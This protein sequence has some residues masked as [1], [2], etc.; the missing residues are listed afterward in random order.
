[1]VEFGSVMELHRAV[2]HCG[3]R[4]RYSLDQIGCAWQWYSM[5]QLGTALEVSRLD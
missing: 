3:A 4:Q 5:V 1:M 2:L